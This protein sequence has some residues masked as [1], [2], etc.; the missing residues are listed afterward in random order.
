MLLVIWKHVS[1]PAVST[2]ARAISRIK[3]SQQVRVIVPD[4]RAQY[5]AVRLFELFKLLE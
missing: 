2:H 4:V 5:V 3:G 1:Y